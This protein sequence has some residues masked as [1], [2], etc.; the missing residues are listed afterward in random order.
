MGENPCWWE[1][2]NI[3][4]IIREGLCSRQNSGMSWK[5]LSPR[6]VSTGVYR[7]TPRKDAGATEQVSPDVLSRERRGFSE[8]LLATAN[9]IQFDL[10]RALIPSNLRQHAK[11]ELEVSVIGVGD[12]VELWDTTSWNTYLE[13]P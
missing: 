12:H 13:S 2:S 10:G 9:E 4:L 7:Y 1:P 8:V 5:A 11:L 6:W 3:N